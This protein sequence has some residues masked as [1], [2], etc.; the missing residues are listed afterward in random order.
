M[1]ERSDNAV[2]GLYPRCHVMNSFFCNKLMDNESTFD[3]LCTY[4]RSVNHT[5]DKNMPVSECMFN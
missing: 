1:Q 3:D 5:K 4:A 2:K